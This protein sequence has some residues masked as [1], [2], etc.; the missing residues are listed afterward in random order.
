MQIL[1]FFREN[2]SPDPLESFLSPK[3]LKIKSIKKNYAKKE[4]KISAPSLKK[5]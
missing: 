2:M 4:T 5:V 3:L 1:K